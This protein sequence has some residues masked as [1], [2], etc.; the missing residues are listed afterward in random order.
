MGDLFGQIITSFI[1]ILLSSCK[2]GGDGGDSGCGS[3]SS[4][5]LINNCVGGS[6]GTYPLNKYNWHLDNNGQK[7]F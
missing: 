3:S 6:S 7:I 2:G 4:G 1:S 5:S